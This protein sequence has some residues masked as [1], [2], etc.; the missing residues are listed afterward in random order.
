MIDLQVDD[1]PGIGTQPVCSG[2]HERVDEAVLL[3]KMLLSE[4]EA[5]TPSNTAF[6][7]HR[8]PKIMVF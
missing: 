5:F 6:A 2:A 4:E 7:L 8:A 3:L 1:A